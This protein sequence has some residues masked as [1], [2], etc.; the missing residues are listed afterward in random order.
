LAADARR[1]RPPRLAPDQ[2]HVL[3]IGTIWKLRNCMTGCV[4]GSSA[5]NNYL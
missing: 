1:A 3:G 4:P 2:G 5:I